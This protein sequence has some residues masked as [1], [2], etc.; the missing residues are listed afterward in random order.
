LEKRNERNFERASASTALV[1][2]MDLA[3][4]AKEIAH[5]KRAKSTKESKA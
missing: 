5:F 3:L 4:G 1:A 2:I